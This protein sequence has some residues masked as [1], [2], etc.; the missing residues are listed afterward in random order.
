M[1][2][3]FNNPTSPEVLSSNVE[4]LGKNTYSGRGIIAG[5]NEEGTRLVQVYW[6]SGRSS[7]SR[8]R[9]FVRDHGGIVRTEAANP[10]L[11][12]DPSLIIYPAMREVARSF[13]VVSNGAQT[14]AVYE[15]MEQGKDFKESLEGCTYEPDE[16]NY[17]PRITVVCTLFKYP[18]ILFSR[19]RKDPES[20]KCIHDVADHPWGSMAFQ[21]GTGYCMTTYSGDGDPLPSFDGNPYSLPLRGSTTAILEFYRDLLSNDHFVAIAVKSISIETGHSYVA[22]HNRYEKVEA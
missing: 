12:K 10:A 4:K 8:N 6:L 14:D 17:T 1:P 5:P 19:L 22:I 15:G 18:H 3:F 13:Y 2:Q 7:N 21:R 11:V 16:P 9:V 20:Q